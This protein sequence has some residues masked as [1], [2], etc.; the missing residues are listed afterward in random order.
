MGL[1]HVGDLLELRPGEEEE[2]AL[3]AADGEA[4]PVLR[5]GHALGLL[6]LGEDG[7]VALGLRRRED[8]LAWRE[9]RGG[10]EEAAE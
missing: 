7:G 5:E 9:A 8:R 1:L 10:K 3:A 6:G 2:G 4:R